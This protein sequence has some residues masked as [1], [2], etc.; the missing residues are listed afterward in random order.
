MFNTNPRYQSFLTNPAVADY[1]SQKL[2][3]YAATLDKYQTSN[4]ICSV[5][6]VA[7]VRVQEK[8]EESA[9]GVMK[10]LRPVSRRC[11]QKRVLKR[12]NHR[13]TEMQRK[14]KETTGGNTWTGMA[15]VVGTGDTAH[16]TT[17]VSTVISRVIDGT[18]ANKGRRI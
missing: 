17:D 5:G 10:E 6:Q 18:N 1:T 3:D 2:L 12:R 14:A 13:S 16:R 11:W 4:S 9:V 8:E 15:T 7:A